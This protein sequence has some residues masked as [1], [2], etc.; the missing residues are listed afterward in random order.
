M[1]RQKLEP[2]NSTYL[3]GPFRFSPSKQLLLRDGMPVRIGAR[4]L[5][6]LT[7]LVRQAGEPV[8]RSDIEEF[9]WPNTLVH[10]SS[11]RVNVA[12]LRRALTG[13]DP[14]ET[15]IVSVPTRGYRFVGQVE[16]VKGDH[17]ASVR[18]A[19][20]IRKTLPETSLVIG[21]S[22]EIV[23]IIEA[24]GK[25]RCVTIVGPGGVG[26]TTVAVAVA[27]QVK[28]DFPG[29]TIFVDLATVGDPQ[30]V[31][32]AIANAVG[33]RHSSDDPIAS[34]ISVL[35]GRQ[36]L[37][38]LDNCEH[39]TA[40][41]NAVVGR[42]LS[43]LADISI[44]STSR[45]PVGAEAEILY[46]LPTLK[47]P[48][49]NG[50]ITAKRALA[51]PA[52]KLFVTRARERGEYILTDADAP[53]V[54]A[55][56][57]RLDGIAL[58]IELAASKTA[59]FGVPK[60]LNMLEQR[61]P[62]LSNGPREAPLRQ[63]TLQATLDWSYRLL[64]VEE[65]TLL[66]FLSV[67]AGTFYVADA[68]ALS[69][70]TSLSPSEAI[71]ALERLTARS[72][73]SIE[74]NSGAM[75]CRL[76][77][78]TRAYAAERLLAEVEH[79]RAMRIYAGYIHVV[80]ERAASEWS[81]REKQS[82]LSEYAPKIND[83]RKVIAWAFADGGDKMLGVTLTASAISLWE[84]LSLVSEFRARVKEALCALKEIG[85]C[86]INS[87]V[88]LA[89]SHASG[90]N[91]AN[92]LVPETEDAW[93]R[94]FELGGEARNPEYQLRGLWGLAIFLIYTGRSPEAVARLNQ[95]K[96]IAE[97]HQDW[98][99]I[100]EA[101][102]LIGMAEIYVGQ[103]TSAKE[104][105]E[106]LSDRF[107]NDKVPVRNTRYNMDQLVAVN[108]SLALV[109]WLVGEPVRAM[110]VIEEAHIRA[111]AIGHIVSQ[112]NLFALG[113]LPITVWSGEI[114]SAERYKTLL[115]ENG[116]QEDIEIWG[117]V[118]RFYRAVLRAKRNE[119]GG[120]ADMK[121]RLED[122]VSYRLTMR[123]PM[124]YSMLA[125]EYLAAGSLDEAKAAIQEARTFADL[126]G[127]KWCLAE[128]LRVDALVQAQ[129][130]N[131]AQASK[132]LKAAIQEAQDIGALTL[133]IRAA[134]N[135]AE[136]LE[137][138]GRAD[139]ALLL[140]EDVYARTGEK[141]AFAGLSSALYRLRGS[142]GAI[143]A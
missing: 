33:A 58:A 128:V 1:A 40:S 3:F 122:L 23:S 127:E 114:E 34:V 130:G 94:C 83:L 100:P 70:S 17:P 42:L 142:R 21:R 98:S 124:H 97:A 117:R 102:R 120:L 54:S 116:R 7:L 61:F 90:L 134:V 92:A 138:E 32:A 64:S 37:L 39:V 44:L 22:A 57:Q 126:P 69:E 6:I 109:L 9:V 79:D 14:D 29:A 27:Y 132:L 113:A 50:A 118:N 115:E 66:R 75:R 112:S 18:Q 62:L 77:E 19:P 46:R 55:I 96:E 15:F 129:S 52:V 81:G 125:E 111:Q 133:E 95:F 25:E 93:L 101:D 68:V 5:D 71:N 35:H 4:S 86:P 20:V 119:S 11:L 82:W 48:F 84:E 123:T 104:R 108:C 41:V 72:L 143:V 89:W 56:C 45:E 137:A 38:I 49:D 2:D 12:A 31:A 91:F 88:R 139:D 121:A 85:D 107:K 136:R 78:S 43:A 24:L 74:H 105:L 28:E 36:A 99:A 59:A 30:Y 73:V 87:R 76:L 26:K 53:L 65:A 131:A 8:S 13:S 47:V 106:A 140:L 110:R 135:L 10:E 141:A 103:L 67:F 63:Q 80:F 16:V 60:L 51:F